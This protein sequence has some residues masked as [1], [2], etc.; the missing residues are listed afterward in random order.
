VYEGK[1]GGRAGGETPQGMAVEMSTGYPT[2][3]LRGETRDKESRG[4]GLK[5]FQG[6]R[7]ERVE[8]IRT[9]VRKGG[10]SLAMVKKVWRGVMGSAELPEKSL[11]N[12]STSSEHIPAG[13]K[14]A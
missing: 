3:R 7:E 13:E 5:G 12:Q 9:D 10:S 11:K 4:G 1:E 8:F 2:L 6:K 14:T